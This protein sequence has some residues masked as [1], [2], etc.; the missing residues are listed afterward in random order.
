MILKIIPLTFLIVLVVY[1][2]FAVFKYTRMIGNIFINL[3]YRPPL[4]N[5]TS[6]VGEPVTILD[7]SGHEIQGI[8]VEHSNAKRCIIFCHESGSSKGSWEKYAYFLPR[9]GFHLLSIDFEDQESGPQIRPM[10]QWPN[11]EKV[12]RLLLVTH[13]VKKATRPDVEII[14]FGIS[15]GADVALAASVYEPNVKAV[16]ADGLFS[17]KGIFRD[18]IRKWGPIL[19]KPN[20]F[21]ERYP[22]W[23]VETF[24]NLGFWYCQGKSGIR[25]VDVEKFLKIQHPPLL[26]IHGEQ[27]DY[28]TPTHM[29]FLEKLNRGNLT[30]LV[31]P[32]AKHNQAV[33]VDKQ[34]YEESIGAFLETI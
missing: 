16:I 30:H 26:M 23:V 6:S 5:L 2:V 33:S 12:E 15:M 21:G 22:A 10:S 9:L 1:A 8:F 18:Y 29:A 11:M 31:I 19:V 34:A 25:F 7:S 27:D 17:M 24:A 13:W 4:E 20:F 28:I 32:Q 14:F 3:V